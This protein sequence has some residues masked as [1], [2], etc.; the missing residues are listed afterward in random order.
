MNFTTSVHLKSKDFPKLTHQNR[1][2]SLGSCFSENIGRKLVDAKFNCL[3]NPFGVLYNP[4]SIALA[5]QEIM[6]NKQYTEADLFQHLELWN[7]WMHHGSFS[8]ISKAETL[9]AINSSVSLAYQQFKELDTLF[10]TFGTAGVY[11]LKSDN[12]IVSNCHKVPNKSF[13]RVQLSVSDIVSLYIPILESVAAL[14]STLKV[15]FTVSPIRH[16]RDGL[17][18]NQ[19]SKATLLLAI[20]E[21]QKRFPNQVVYFPAYEI[22]LDELRD[23]RFYADDMVHPSSLAIAYIWEK[24]Q[25]VFFT[26]QTIAVIEECD[27]IKKGLEHKPLNPNTKEYASFLEQLVLKMNRISKKNP[28]LDFRKEIEQCLIQ[29]NKLKKL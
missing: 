12:R 19:R 21:L 15:V 9:Q 5:L 10:I 1:M 14:N 3:V 23:Y 17:I 28:T 11:H 24:L 29:L 13:D 22:M 20:S 8:F 18:E 25:A 26:E 7:S 2:M 6:A 4:A 16:V 27:K